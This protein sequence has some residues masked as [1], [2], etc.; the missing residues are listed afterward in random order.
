MQTFRSVLSKSGSLYMPSMPRISGQ[1]AVRAFEKAG[2]RQD[3]MAGSHCI[4]KK[5]G[6]PY[7]LS[8]PLHKG[9]TLGTGLLKSQIEA[10]GLTVDQFIALL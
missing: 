4:M 8:I 10:A 5:A 6:H 7:H 3:R 2:F 1:D 9:E